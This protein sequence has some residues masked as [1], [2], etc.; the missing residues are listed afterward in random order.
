VSQAQISGVSAVIATA[1]KVLSSK[2]TSLFQHAYKVFNASHLEG[3]VEKARARNAP[4]AAEH[5]PAPDVILLDLDM[6]DLT[7]EHVARLRAE[8]E[9]APG[10]ILLA[11]SGEEALP[12]LRAGAEDWV[13]KPV[14]WDDLRTRIRKLL[15][16]HALQR[17]TEVPAMDPPLPH[18]VESLH[19]PEDGHL[20]ARE[21]AD[22]FGLR[23]AELA[24]AIGR[25]VSTV[26]K[27]PT[28]GGLQHSLRPFEAMASGLLRLTG[29]RQRALMWL[30]AA[31]PALEG[32]APIEW[33]KQGNIAAL[34]SFI[35][36]LLE[37]RPA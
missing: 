25:G 22:F 21:V 17:R 28:A 1:D 7:A 20:D 34:A 9:D 26:H 31:N 14:R 16:E 32:H 33:V 29:S 5:E 2:A 24:R 10:I 12:A 23:L 19:N 11:S 4:T 15:E 30:N 6:P 18:L 3:A 8:T 27:T 37:G 36:D 13:L 35:Q